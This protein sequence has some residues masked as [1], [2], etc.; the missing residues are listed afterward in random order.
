[1]I[2]M[3]RFAREVHI[4]ARAADVWAAMM[5]LENWP[6]WASQFKRLERLDG[7]GLALKSR[8]RVWPKG[9]PASVWQVTEYEEG[10]SFTWVSRV[11]PGVQIMGGHLL[12]PTAHGTTA[13]FWLETN[14][15]LGSALGPILR[16]LVFSS[17]TRTAT[18]GLK[19]HVEQHAPATARS[20]ATPS[21]QPS[22]NLV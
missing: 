11:G 4:D 22:E 1:V 17:N 7:V 12:T 10:R 21:H 15:P 2:E 19:H 13:Q 6:R 5:D 18:E 14:G 20:D 9:L 8:V 16:H 3:S